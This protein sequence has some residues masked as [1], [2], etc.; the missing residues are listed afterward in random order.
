MKQRQ[1]IHIICFLKDICVCKKTALF[2]D[3][4]PCMTYYGTVEG[5]VVG[6]SASSAA[7]PCRCFMKDTQKLG[8]PKTMRHHPKTTF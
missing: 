2:A 5:E 1:I 7:V 6:S 8:T 4:A 3:T